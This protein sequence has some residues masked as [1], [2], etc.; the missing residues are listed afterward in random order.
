MRFGHLH[1]RCD[2]PL[3]VWDDMPSCQQKAHSPT[4]PPPP[5][6]AHISHVEADPGEG[7]ITTMKATTN[8]TNAFRVPAGTVQETTASSLGNSLYRH[9]P[10]KWQQ[11]LHQQDDPSSAPQPDPSTPAKPQ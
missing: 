11:H 8:P 2:S 6:T 10:A 7:H 3:H 1:S 4:L 5:A 9:A